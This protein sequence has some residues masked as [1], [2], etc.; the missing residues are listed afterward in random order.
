MRLSKLLARPLLVPCLLSIAAGI[1]A[2]QSSNRIVTF[3]STITIGR[4][5]TLSVSERFEIVS[6]GVSFSDGFHR[7]LGIKPAG[8]QRAKVGGIDSITAKVDGTGGIIQTSGDGNILDIKI[9][10]QSNILPGGTHTIELNYTAKHQFLIY[11]DSE[12]L[13]QDISGAWP[14][15]IDK[16]AV[17]L[18]FPEGLPNDSSVSAGTGTDSNVQF[19]CLRT[20][21]P[22]GVKFET[23]R[24]LAP[25]NRLYISARFQRGY[26]V[27]N[28]GEDGFRA[29]FQ[30]HPMLFPWLAFLAG[31]FVFTAAGLAVAKPALKL[32]RTGPAVLSEHR[33][34]LA[35]AALATALSAAS[36]FVFREP[37]SAMPGLGLGAIASSVISGNPHGG[38]PIS[39]VAVGVASNL[40]FYYL[41]ARGGRWIWH[42]L[43]AS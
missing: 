2:G 13:N 31:L 18:I 5:R 16:A 40:I 38:D 35:V 34:A 15:P 24:P 25:G 10:P 12:D 32:W 22:N 36:L 27:S 42:R 37:Y 29:V 4:D 19:D 11:G 7:R 20:A 8:P 6:D 21:L 43:R 28:A 23:S 39:L 33:I 41:V 3:D 14:V 9:S 1:A 26:F 30:N 17:A